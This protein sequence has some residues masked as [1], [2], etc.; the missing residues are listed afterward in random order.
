MRHVVPLGEGK[1]LKGKMLM[2]GLLESTKKAQEKH[3]QRNDSR[4]KESLQGHE[5]PI[6]ELEAAAMLDSHGGINQNPRGTLLNQ[7]WSH[8]RQRQKNAHY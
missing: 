2:S 8:A 6:V 3:V 1:V 7:K 4:C 5:D